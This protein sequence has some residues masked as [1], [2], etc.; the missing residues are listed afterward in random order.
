MSSHI[1]LL[2]PD[3]ILG[4]TYQS[5]LAKG[6][7]DVRWFRSASRAIASIDKDL[8]DLI[9]IEL[10]LPKHNGVEFLY[11]L[12]SYQDLV[13]IPVVVLSNIPPVLKAFRAGLWENLGVVAYHYKPLTKLADLSRSVER[14]MAS[15]S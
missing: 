10:Q 12:R 13:K 5:I 6:G 15:T 14:I 4:R 3:A 7:H 1:L 8:P 11:E 2:E 9:V